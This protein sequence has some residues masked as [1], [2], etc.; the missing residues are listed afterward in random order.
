LEVEGVSKLYERRGWRTLLGRAAPVQTRALNDISFRVRPGE[1]LGLLGPNGAGKTTMLKILTGLLYPTSGRVR[2]D[3]RDMQLERRMVRGLMGLVTC[4]ER[5]FY[6]RLSGRRNLRFFALLY[7]LPREIVEDRIAELLE[8]LGLTYAAD[9]PYSGYS[10]GMKQKLAIARG[11]LS[12]PRILLYDEPTRSLDPVSAM[13]IRR[14]IAERREK[15]PEQTHVLATNL[16]DEAEM[17]CDRVVIINR[18][19]IAAQGPIREIQERFNER[20]YEDHTITYRGGSGTEWLTPDSEHGLL[21]VAFED[22]TSR[23]DVVRIRT[24]RN[25]DAF[26]R[27]LGRL[28]EEGATIVE[29]SRTEAAFDEVFCSLVLSDNRHAEAVLS[30]GAT[31]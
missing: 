10:S 14:W 7:G 20:E 19:R 24:I 6:W 28:L 4:D 15:N 3:G 31:P 12:N 8:A 11:L 17:L 18:G 1:T 21:E 13:T 2:I 26:S 23:G 25:S 27:V 29:C 30:E 16:L 22:S 9:R 5:S